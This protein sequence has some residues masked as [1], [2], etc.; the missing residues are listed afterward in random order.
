MSKKNA[1]GYI[2]MTAFYA[3]KA[4][5]REIERKRHKPR[6]R[7]NCGNKKRKVDVCERI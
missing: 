6:I 3:I 1:S 7:N 2:D 4:A 5:D